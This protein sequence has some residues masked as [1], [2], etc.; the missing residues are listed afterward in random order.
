MRW[1][2]LRI[3]KGVGGSLQRPPRCL[4]ES[5]PELVGGNGI[6]E[7]CRMAADPAQPSIVCLCSSAAAPAS[8]LASP[9]RSISRCDRWRTCLQPL[10]HVLS[11]QVHQAL[12]HNIR[13]SLVVQ[14]HQL[15]ARL[16]QVLCV[17]L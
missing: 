17:R 7:G 10:L 9:P 4:P 14:Q 2:E 15:V 1:F 12:A 5:L 11:G 13:C 8:Q 16:L 3:S 6:W